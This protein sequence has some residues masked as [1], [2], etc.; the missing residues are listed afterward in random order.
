MS[1]YCF[2]LGSEPCKGWILRVLLVRGLGALVVFLRTDEGSV[3]RRQ[4]MAFGRLNM[5][6]PGFATMG[7]PARS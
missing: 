7:N 4:G 3:A 6:H 5:P 1:P 2:F